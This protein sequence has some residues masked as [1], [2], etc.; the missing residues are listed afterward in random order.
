MTKQNIKIVMEAKNV[1]YLE[2]PHTIFKFKTA[3]FSVDDIQIE[4]INANHYNM[5]AIKYL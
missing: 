3:G 2:K 1:S 5:T 4:R